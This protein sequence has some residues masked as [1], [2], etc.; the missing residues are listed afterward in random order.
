MNLGNSRPNGDKPFIVAGMP[1][2][3]EE[4]TIGSVV[5][6]TLAHVDAVICINDGLSLIHI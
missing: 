2:Y 1:M 5:F 6:Q 4:E 3:N